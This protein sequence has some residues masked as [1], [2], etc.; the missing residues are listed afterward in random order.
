MKL[1]LIDNSHYKLNQSQARQLCIEPR[2]PK[3]GHMMKADPAKLAGIELC[4]RRPIDG[5]PVPMDHCKIEQ[6]REAW[7]LRTPLSWWDGAEVEQGWTWALH[8]CWR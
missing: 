5:E 4:K 8:V 6:A 2:L 3:H 7:I 1:L